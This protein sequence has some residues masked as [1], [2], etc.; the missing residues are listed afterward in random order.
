MADTTLFLFFFIFILAPLLLAW[1]LVDCD[2]ANTVTIDGLDLDDMGFWAVK[3]E[4]VYVHYAELDFLMDDSDSDDD[5]DFHAEQEGNDVCLDWPDIEREVWSIEHVACAYPNHAEPL[6]GDLNDDSDEE[7]EAFRTETWGT[8]DVMPHT[9]TS[10]NLAA[11]LESASQL[12]GEQN[13]HVLCMGSKLHAAPSASLFSSFLPL[14]QLDTLACKNPPREGTTSKWHAIN[15]CPERWD[16]PDLLC[17]EGAA[18]EQCDTEAHCPETWKPPGLHDKVLQESGGVL[19]APGNA[20]VI[21]D[22]L[23]P[24]ALAKNTDVRLPKP[25]SINMHER[26][27]A[28]P[29]M[30]AAP[31]LAKDTA[32]VEPASKAKKAIAAKSEVLV[33][34]AQCKARCKVKMPL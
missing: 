17:G 8:E 12:E 30:G 7:W 23:R 25:L 19:S 6:M 11:C 29:V 1:R 27:G 22:L 33:P 4:E 16:L 34:W 21:Q 18:I 20:P 3:E 24:A 15:T 9:L 31:A 2:T 14:L 10:T 13:F 26:G 28:L 5:L 32:G